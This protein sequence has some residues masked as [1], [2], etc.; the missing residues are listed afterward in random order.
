VKEEDKVD[1]KMPSD[2][3][4]ALVGDG[5]EGLTTHERKGW[6]DS[7]RLRGFIDLARMVVSSRKREPKHGVKASRGRRMRRSD[8]RHAANKVARR[9]RKTSAKSGA[10]GSSRQTWRKKR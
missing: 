7:G 2:E 6:F 1:F 8:R 9:S 3:E 4:I 5:T 10:T